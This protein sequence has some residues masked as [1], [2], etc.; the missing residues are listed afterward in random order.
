MADP[1]TLKKKLHSLL[2]Q[3]KAA[4]LD[5]DGLLADS[6]PYHYR[7]YNEVFE[8]YGYADTINAYRTRDQIAVGFKGYQTMPGTDITFW[9]EKV[10]LT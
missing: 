4:V 3:S 8:R 5:F 10:R 1:L 6:E 9:T 2:T 7:A